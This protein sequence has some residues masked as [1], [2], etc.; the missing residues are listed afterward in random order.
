VT[1]PGV[2]FVS[3]FLSSAG[4]NR[5]YAD[6]LADRLEARGWPVT[7][8]SAQ[9]RRLARLADMLAMTWKRRR[10]YAVAHVD[11]FSGS[12]FVW[13]EAVCLELQK[14]R[15]PYV[16]TLRGGNLPEFARRWPR[17]VRRLL[18]SAA[19]VTVPSRYLAA[20]MSA[21]RRDLMLVRN[22]IETA[23]YRFSER[24][25]PRPRLVWVRAFHAV[26]NPMLAVDVLVRLRA[27]H[28]DATLHMLGPDKDGSRDLVER[29]AREL[30]VADR[31]TIQGQVP[32]QEIPDHLGEADLFINTTD[33][34][35]APIS[36]LEAMAAGLCVVSTSVGGIP[37]LLEHERTALLVPPRD[38]DAMTAAIERVLAE[39]ELARK[40]SRE[41]HQFACGCD[42][43]PVLETWQSVL[44]GTASRA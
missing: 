17:R 5:V 26:Y 1:P 10:D 33:V 29:H 7:R 22:A 25:A 8:T 6:E 35:N 23:A 15:K 13:A 31:L 27:R 16:L 36:V 37:Y 44:E 14:L 42:W 32:K 41:A 34:D 20:Q 11:V 21:Y 39:R 19:L 18:R 2:L 28:A 30:G 38:P 12:A 4:F 43:A 24:T 40:L 3:N 9:P